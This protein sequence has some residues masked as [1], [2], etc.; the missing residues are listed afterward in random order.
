[1]QNVTY[2]L[3]FMRHTLLEKHRL[4]TELATD[5]DENRSLNA[6]ATEMATDE[7]R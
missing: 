3:Y 1:M 7:N 4:A 5:F 2:H 6:L